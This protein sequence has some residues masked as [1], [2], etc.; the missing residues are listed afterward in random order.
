MPLIPKLGIIRTMSFPMGRERPHRLGSRKNILQVSDPEIFREEITKRLQPEALQQP[1]MQQ[2]LHTV[3]A[4]QQPSTKLHTY[5]MLSRMAKAG[6]TDASALSVIA[7]YQIIKDEGV[8]GLDE[9]PW[10]QQF[11]KE[12]EKYLADQ[13]QFLTK[14]YKPSGEREHASVLDYAGHHPEFRY[15]PLIALYDSID[16]LNDMPQLT[17]TPENQ[18]HIQDSWTMLT[19]I[20]KYMFGLVERISEHN[21]HAEVIQELRQAYKKAVAHTPTQHAP[22][23][24]F[25]HDYNQPVITGNTLLVTGY[26]VGANRL[27]TRMQLPDENSLQMST[28]LQDEVVDIQSKQPLQHVVLSMDI[29]TDIAGLLATAGIGMPVDVYLPY[30]T[31]SFRRSI[32]RKTKLPHW[33]AFLHRMQEFKRD[34]YLANVTYHEAVFV[35]DLDHPVTRQTLGTK[36]GKAYEEL[37][38]AMVEELQVADSDKRIVLAVWDANDHSSTTAHAVEEARQHISSEDNL[39]IV[40]RGL[41]PPTQ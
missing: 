28:G 13:E 33:P 1:D 23:I 18:Q 12:A 36:R 26:G 22:V 30:D 38:H 37:N 29:G 16:R 5:H 41:I 2:L 25:P 17:A 4:L 24:T 20:R 39:H 10:L 21:V 31:T 6:V 35:A 40:T 9:S 32:L 3:D 15:I 7:T 11:R 34:R 14:Q 19:Q 8:N 27:A